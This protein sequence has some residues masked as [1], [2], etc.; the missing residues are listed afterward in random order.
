[1]KK[2]RYLIYHL[3]RMD[4]LVVNPFIKSETAQIQDPIFLLGNQGGGNT[5]L[6]RVLR[7]NKNIVSACGNS[8]YWTCADEM[9]KVFELALPPEL[10]LAS[11]ITK[12][13]PP[14]DIYTLPRSWSYGTNAL[15]KK[16]YLNENDCSVVIKHKFLR[17]I[18]K[19]INR[20]KLT[21]KPRFFDKSQVYTLKSRLVQEAL[22]EHNPYFILMTR[23]PIV[24]C[25]RA[26]SGKA[27]DM[28][29]YNHLTMKQKVIACAE[30]WNN[31]MRTIYED[32]K[33]LDNFFMLKFE[34]LL[35]DPETKIRDICNYLQLKFDIDMM[36]K[37]EHKIPYA[38]K[39]LDRWWPLRVKVNKQYNVPENYKK[40]ITEICGETAGKL[41]YKI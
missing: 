6:S 24:S 8:N 35:V 2:L 36:P 26:A 17:V 28:A 14:Y 12:S 33:C 29:R 9:Q 41:N 32:S 37:K 21:E 1:M 3:R 31:C 40:I 5:F 23:E 27:G 20:Y 15:Y 19:C 34:D 25:Y 38:T 18:G 7:R 4:W 11:N 16:Y 22:R 13:D 10:R 30:H 39:Y